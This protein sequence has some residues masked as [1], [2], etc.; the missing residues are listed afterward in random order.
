[1]AVLEK[2]RSRAGLLVGLIALALLSFII[3]GLF[4]PGSS[5]FGGRGN[6]IGEINGH[7]IS[8]E[9]FQKNLSEME[10]KVAENQ[11]AP[12]D[13]NTREQLVNQVWSDF[14]DK[15]LFDEYIEDAG[16]AVS[17]AELHDMVQ[18]QDIDPQVKG[19]PIFQDSITKQFNVNLVKRFLEVQLTEE[20]DPD[21]KF[22]RSWNEFQAS[23]KKQKLKSKYN[24]LIRK[25]IYTTTALAK[26]DFQ[27]KNATSYYRI[28][29]KGYE[30]ISDSTVKPTDE[31]FK[32]YYDA[33]KNEFEQP[34]ETRK[35][36][37][38]SFQVNPTAQD[39]EQI[40]Q[41]MEKLKAEFQA[42][43]DD[44]G[45][46]NVNSV[47]PYTQKAVRK[48]QLSPQ[49]DSAVFAGT[50]GSV[51]GPYV[52]GEQVKIA[53]L[54][55]FKTSSDS[56]KARH[57]LIST[58]NKG[59][60][61]K[62]ATHLADSLKQL[63]QK[64]ADFGALAMQISDDQG[65]KLKGGDL[66]FFTEGMMVKPFN[67]ACFNG[68]PGDLA[69]VESQFGVHLIHIQEKTK[70]Y[71]KALMAYVVRDIEPSTETTDKLYS[72]ANDFA[73]M[74]QNYDVFK[75]EAEEKQYVI[76]EF[77][78]LKANERNI[79]DLTN[80]REIVQWTF[81]PDRELNEVSKVF[82]LD[83]KYVVVAYTGKKNKGIPTLDQVRKQIEPM[84]RK[85]KKGEM[86]AAEMQKAM[87]GARTLEEA[88]QKMNL[89]ADSTLGVHFSTYTLEGYG[90]EP[91]VIGTICGGKPNSF[92]EPVQGNKGVY[93]VFVEKHENTV[94]PPTD[95]TE[96]RRQ[97][98]SALRGRAD[99]G[100]YNSILKKGN[101]EDKRSLYF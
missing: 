62:K 99:S 51:F 82:N 98:A 35:I 41:S 74:A 36:E 92:T 18:G 30:T 93:M 87:Q 100:I 81:N 2:I 84:V 72:Q 64:G 50:A 95:W 91:K 27:E 59:M 52:E 37:Y 28:A 24:N 10:A 88:A 65:S 90:F 31:D 86:I 97:V 79:N 15:F 23:L 3:Q 101:V 85:V 68:N 6:S 69:V 34:E 4:S 9:E 78:N 5:L 44:T 67:D 22:R 42:S 56:V 40:I 8:G 48:G 32:K 43:S 57:I 39:R 45:F 11:N 96:T 1:M 61:V 75:K 26:H 83:R 16:I 17:D 94:T 53:K 55:G 73:V 19:I 77:D 46:V 76:A 63:V 49:I 7:E 20:N 47:E 80:C 29:L 25:A 54:E 14:L 70:P 38:V 60:D 89:K 21:G 12:V 66:G 71:N 58:N 33:H 13:E